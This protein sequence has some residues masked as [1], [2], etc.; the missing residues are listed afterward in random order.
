MKKFFFFLFLVVCTAAAWMFFQTQDIDITLTT[1]Q[2]HTNSSVPA[3]EEPE[4]NV[5]QSAES[6]VEHMTMQVAKSAPIIQLYRVNTD[7]FDIRFHH[8]ADTPQT[9]LDWQKSLGAVLVINGVYFHEDNM[10]SGFLVSQGTRIGKRSF[11][12]DK[13]AVIRLQPTPAIIDTA[14]DPQ[15][16]TEETEATQSY[17]L[18]I[19]TGKAAVETDSEKLARR[20]FLATDNSNQLYFGIVNSQI[21]LF[22][23]SQWLSKAPVSFD[24]AV[25]LDGGPSTGI[26]TDDDHE[27]A[28]NSFTPV[29]N[30]IAVAPR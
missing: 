21:S 18:L 12:Q 28:S 17:P 4:Y 15:V 9:V 30:V 20:S 27:A 29:P 22:E 5:W 23:L 26:I 7:D 8:S 10:P 24:M 11:D 3:I 25:N 19:R 14:E 2:E 6:G 13:S 1:E 16:L